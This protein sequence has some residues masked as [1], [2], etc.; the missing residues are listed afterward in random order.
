MGRNR[1]AATVEASTATDAELAG[2]AAG[3]EI[4]AFEELYR[5]HAQ[6]AWRVAQAVT[7]NA[8]DSADAVSDA[9]IRVFKALPTGRLTANANFRAYLLTATRNAALD[10]HRR[11][12]RVRPSDDDKVFDRA[13]GDAPTDK[14][15]A[16]LDAAM[17][18]TAFRSLPERWRSVLWLTEVEGI[19][20]RE[21]A[22]MLGVS[23]NGV[24][25]L[26]VRARAGLRERFL[27]AHI[28]HRAVDDGCRATVEKL[29]A[30]VAGALA[31]RDLAKVDQHLAGCEGC[32]ARKDELEE[33]GSN[34]R[35]IVLPIPLGLGA[36]A[37]AKWELASS[38]AVA[39]GS[40]ASALPKWLEKAQGPLAVMSIGLFAAGIVG[41]GVVGQPDSPRGS[42]PRS[43]EGATD[44]AAPSVNFTPAASF[45][46]TSTA[47]GSSITGSGF[48]SR[49]V[50][51]SD[52]G[53]GSDTGS[54]GFSDD[55]SAASDA[56]LDALENST[57]PTATTL[58]PVTTPTTQPTTTT[59]TT[60]PTST[61]TTQPPAKPTAQLVVSVGE[62]AIAAGAG[63]NSCTGV[64]VATTSA[65]DGCAATKDGGVYVETTSTTIK[66]L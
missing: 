55:D 17:V 18:A 40:S 33:L 27:Q 37:V 52:T 11:T 8:E 3:G 60:Q 13:S 36:L 10:V 19:P 20:A 42:G 39:A 56:E 4:D 61:T 63:Q 2:Q 28:T 47:D 48:G 9:F 57:S 45:N 25:Q 15:M 14:A 46:G 12:G 7:G 23:A 38:G 21:A 49:V 54:R 35:R 30:Y 24:A 62:A 16:R 32:R 44:L 34:L 29:G 65:P 58:P 53:R 26:A 6:A 22:G 64:A 59:T 50:G 66:I 31:P 43:T 41:M 5:R 1:T 51:G